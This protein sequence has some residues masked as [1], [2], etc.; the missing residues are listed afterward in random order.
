VFVRFGHVIFRII[1]SAVFSLKIISARTEKI[2]N[3]ESLIAELFLRA[4]LHTQSILPPYFVEHCA[5][6]TKYTSELMPRRKMWCVGGF[7][8]FVY[9]L[10]ENVAAFVSLGQIPLSLIRSC[11]E[12][13]GMP[14]IAR[15]IG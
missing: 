12:V 5:S 7:I 3:R 1:I 9:F 4:F 6:L 8:H 13:E 15:S 14:V 2:K 11:R 10:R